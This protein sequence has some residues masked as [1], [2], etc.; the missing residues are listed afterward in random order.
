MNDLERGYIAGIIDGEGFFGMGR[1]KPPSAN[2]RWMYHTWCVIA[3]SDR[4]LLEWLQERV[5][6]RIAAGRQRAPGW[7]TY[8][9]L[10]IQ[11]GALRKALEWLPDVLRVKRPQ[12]ILMRE[13]LR[14]VDR[15][16]GTFR[17]YDY[18]E[19]RE[20][21]HKAFKFLNARG[22]LKTLGEFGEPLLGD[23]AEPSDKGDFVDGVTARLHAF[24]PTYTPMGTKLPC[25][26]C[27]GPM[28]RYKGRGYPNGS[29]VCRQ[30]RWQ[31]YREEKAR[32][33][34][35]AQPEAAASVMT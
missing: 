35:S 22:P 24:T 26:R 6:G 25:P 13:Y 21:A 4:A 1:A 15:H 10:V 27:G 30:C 28:Y 7:K 12:A 34:M 8:Y 23:N 31:V 14:M 16:K 20:L 17:W 32:R 9:Q 11:H 3:Q 5:G 29:G 18:T 19:P 2:G 33:S